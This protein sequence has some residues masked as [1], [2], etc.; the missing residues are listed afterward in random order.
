M[1]RLSLF[2]SS[3]AVLSAAAL[4]A[5]ATKPGPLTPKHPA[6]ASS[7]SGALTIDGKLS[8]PVVHMDGSE[9]YAEYTVRLD[10][11]T[12]P[13]AD[14]PISMALVL[15]RSGSMSGAKLE[16]ARR[17]AHRFV[18]LL[19]GR[20]ELAF[21]TFSDQVESTELLTM[22]D[23]NKVTVH[24]AIDAVT[25]S[26]A[27]YLS[28][29]IERG[30]SALAMARGARRMVVVS[31]GQPTVGA[32]DEPALVSLVGRAHDGSITVTALGVGAEYDGLLMQHLAERGGGMY[33]YLRDAT[34][35][36]DVLGKEV[37]AARSARVRN[38]ELVLESRDLQ[39]VEVP[40]RHVR[41]TVDGAVLHLA[42]LRP[43]APTRV[44]VRLQ[45]RRSAPESELGLKATL[46]W[47]PLEGESQSS[48]ITVSTRTVDDTD[49]VVTRREESLWA[50]GVSAAGSMRMVAAA[51]AWERGD[52]A[53]ASNLLDNAKSLF[54]M[55]ADA[56][57]GQS[58]VDTMRRDFGNA[59]GSERKELS[60]KLEKKKLL[61]FG[62]ENEGY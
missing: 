30:T 52:Y 11:E 54:G 32:V 18:E 49:L 35:L 24:G 2:L 7:H 4:L 5:V 55:S 43:G 50:K 36:E 12:T 10:D 40:G 37:A 58:E 17:A 47:R 34:A 3:A 19:D 25:A 1:N 39:V 9:L 26:G 15:D 20:D 31:D 57:A 14:Q 45:S 48:A 13:T 53:G 22:T 29:G 51:A 27:T 38:V 56:L 61:N 28:G 59:S 16:D 21:I 46:R 33:G 6:A 44:L 42:D 8:H 60:R 23:A 41:N 62:R